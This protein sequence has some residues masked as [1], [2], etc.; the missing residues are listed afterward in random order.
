MIPLRTDRQLKHTPWVN[1]SLI[2]VNVLIFLWQDQAARAGSGRE[3]DRFVFDPLA[4]QWY[5]YFTYQF[6]HGNWQHILFNMVFLYVFGNSLE[7]RLGPIGYGLFYLAG[8][9]VAALG[10]SLTEE[11]PMLGASGSIAA[12]TGAYLALFPMTRVTILWWFIII[13]LI[14]IPSMYLILFV[15]LQDVFFQLIGGERVAYTAHISGNIFGFAVGM[16]ILATRLLP[17]EPY[18]FLS[19]LDRWNRRRRFR[20]MARGGTSP[21]QADAAGQ[22]RPSQQPSPQMRQVMETR[23]SVMR[24]LADHK[25]P[26]AVAAYGQLL[27]L[28]PLHS[29]PRQSQLDLANYA[30]TTEHYETAATAYETFLRVYPTD[31]FASSADVHLILGLLYGRYLDQPERAVPLLQHAAATLRD[32]SRKAMAEQLMADIA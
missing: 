23:A 24:D 16:G 4:T 18:D 14:E 27:R 10:F 11:T 8:G 25:G 9:V 3:F 32:P 20:S 12:V 7:D 31:R 2:V 6:L 1:I 28:D 15:F 19:L 30:M 13:H 5:Q 22:M 29:L 21:W 26:Q 17:R